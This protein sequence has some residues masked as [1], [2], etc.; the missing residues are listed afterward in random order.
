LLGLVWEK[1]VQGEGC[2]H[3]VDDS[4]VWGFAMSDW[5]STLNG[6]SDAGG[7]GGYDD[8][9]IPSTR[10]LETILDCRFGSPCLDPTFGPSST[11][12]YWTSISSEGAPSDAV[13]ID[14]GGSGRVGMAKIG[15]AHVRAVRGGRS[16]SW[17]PGGQATSSKGA[18]RGCSSRRGCVSRVASSLPS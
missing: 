14:F 1:K 18:S 9:R 7:L 10:E 12:C 5:L 16:S 13:T 3:C 11:S 2:L 15:F 6:T 4:Y 17:K 8:W